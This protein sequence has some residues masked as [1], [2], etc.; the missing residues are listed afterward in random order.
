[1]LDP[2]AGCAAADCG[3]AAK[4]PKAPGTAAAIDFI[5]VFRV[6]IILWRVTRFVSPA[7]G[8]LFYIAGMTPGRRL[9]ARDARRLLRSTVDAMVLDCGKARAYG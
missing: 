4:P 6:T 1:M 7:G 3:E 2:P 9:D 5:N 8:S